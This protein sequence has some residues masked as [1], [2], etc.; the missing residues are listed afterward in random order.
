MK[1]N[2]QIYACESKQGIPQYLRGLQSEWKFVKMKW[3][4]KLEYSEKAIKF[5]KI[6]HLKLDATE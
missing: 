3:V 5:E 6:F 2:R 1:K 4:V